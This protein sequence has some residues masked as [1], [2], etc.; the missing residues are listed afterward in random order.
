MA[1]AEKALDDGR[2]D[3]AVRV[4]SYLAERSPDGQSLELLARVQLAK[5]S[6]T[7]G[8]EATVARQA[9]ADAYRRAADLEPSNAGLQDAAG[10]VVDS[11]GAVE[12]AL[13]YYDRAVALQPSSPMFLLHRGN[14]RLRSGDRAGALADAAALLAAAPREPW[15]HALAA[16]CA[17]PGPEGG[18][19]ASKAIEEA[20]AAQQL[21]P[22]EVGF[23]LLHAKALRLAGR[24]HESVE[25]L[26]ALE[27]R[28]RAGQA[29]AAE[30]ALGW[31]AMDRPDKAGEAWELVLRAKSDDLRAALEAGKARLKAGDRMRAGMWLDRAKAIAP[32]SPEVAELAAAIAAAPAG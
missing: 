27:E 18:G 13:P 14:A 5:A 2:I 15:A 6:N 22:S 29:V 8:P 17:L 24:P 31:M 9:A 16:E 26:T 32:E 11:T 12:A 10:M 21:A 1:T 25:L 7:R 3:D 28:D 20:K 19:D 4:A 23:R 30:L